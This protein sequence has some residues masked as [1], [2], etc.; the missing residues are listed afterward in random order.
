MMTSFDDT[1]AAAVRVD[2]IL[3]ALARDRVPHRAVDAH[4]L[5]TLM[6]TFP[7]VARLPVDAHE[8]AAEI[9]RWIGALPASRQRKLAEILERDGTLAPWRA[10]RGPQTQLVESMQSVDL[11]LAAGAAGSSKTDGA[12]GGG[13]LSSSRV[14]FVRGTVGELSEV[15]QRIAAVTGDIENRNR[16]EQRWEISAPWGY[17]ERGVVVSWLGL[18]DEGQALKVQGRP[19]T[20]LVC[21]DAASG[22]LTA[23]ALTFVQQW[24]RATST[25]KTT[26]VLTANPPTSR[27]AL[28]LR[29]DLFAPWLLPGH[30]RPAESGE[31]R[32]FVRGEEAPAGTPGAESRTAIMSLTSDNPFYVRSGYADRLANIADPVVRARLAFNDWG[33]GFDDD[34]PFQVIPSGEVDKAMARWTPE[35]AGPCDAIG[36]DVARGG[37][38]RSALVRRHAH[39]YSWPI[40]AEGRDT[41][42]GQTFAAFALGNY[43]DGATI[44]ID[45]TGVGASPY[46]ILREQVPT[47]GVIFG[48]GTDALN[49]SQAFGFF[50]VRSWLWWRYRELLIA[51]RVALPP[52]P[53]IKRELCTPRYEMRGKRL[54]VESR[55]K[56][57]KRLG[58]SPDL[59]TAYILAAIPADSMLAANAQNDLRAILARANE[60]WNEHEN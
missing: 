38:D 30:P 53:R 39:W 22:W 48:A 60:R 8:R 3:N 33:A 23:D 57:I 1:F 26:T 18:S 37:D 51:G 49:E 24:L 12:I 55:D 45:A 14:R 32:W 28:Y 2:T 25:E 31:V 52:D 15:L 19:A 21:D 7:D 41:P 17:R 13:L 47:S 9:E 16:S 50:N 46:D 5:A 29:D 54:Y 44:F 35:P 4:V 6:V 10:L 34:D 36:A 20:M 27:E 11:I 58:R 42:D 40:V 59:A 56:I 43:L